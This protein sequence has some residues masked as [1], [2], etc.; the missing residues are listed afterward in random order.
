M[1]APPQDEYNHE[2]KLID[3]MLKKGDELTEE[4]VIEVFEYSFS[5]DIIKKEPYNRAYLEIKKA[6]EA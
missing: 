5:Q 3:Q 1:G 6:I 2:A 4:L